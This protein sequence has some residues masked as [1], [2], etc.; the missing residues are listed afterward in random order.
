MGKETEENPVSPP[1]NT[2]IPLLTALLE[3][4]AVG[5][6]N[7]ELLWVGLHFLLRLCLLLLQVIVSFELGA[8]LAVS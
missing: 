5:V 6:D 2:Q 4:D 1:P 3:E 7:I 8:A